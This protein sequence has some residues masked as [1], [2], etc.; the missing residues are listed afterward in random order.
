MVELRRAGASLPELAC[1][2]GI[3]KQRVYQVVEQLDPTANLQGTATR[4]IQQRMRTV[5]QQQMHRRPRDKMERATPIVLEL[6]DKG[7]LQVD[8]ARLTELSQSTVSAILL[9]NGRRTYPARTRSTST[10][11]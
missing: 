4:L 8:I 5:L 11:F 7:L 3:S 1:K 6:R 10:S 9:R 2:F